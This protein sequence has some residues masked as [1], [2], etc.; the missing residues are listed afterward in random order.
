MEKYVV[1]S[2]YHFRKNK[3]QYLSFSIIVLIA[4]MIFGVGLVTIRSFGKMYG[5]KFEKYACADVYYTLYDSDWGDT[6]LDKAKAIDGIKEAETRKNIMLS[7]DASYANTGNTLNHIFFNMDEKHEMNQLE[8]IGETLDLSGVS[9]PIYISYWIK[10]NGCKIGDTYKY[11][12]GDTT[13]N[14]TIAGF[15]E[16]LMYG[17]NNCGNLAVYLPENE[18][19]AMYDKTSPN[20]H[21][22]TLALRLND[23]SAGKEIFNKLS[24]ILAGNIIKSYTYNYGYLDMS[25]R[26]RTVTANILAAILVAFSALLVIITMFVINFRIKS[27]IQ[28]EMQNMGVL[29][30]MGYTTRQVIWSMALPYI[31]LGA[32]C[33]VCGLIGSYLFLPVLQGVFG[34]LSGLIWNKPMDLM[35]MVYII[36]VILGLIILTSLFSSRKIKKL[37]PIDALRSGIKHHNFKKN[38]FPLDQTRASINITF[39]LKGLVGSIKQSIFLFVIFTIVTFTTIFMVSGLYNSV[40]EPDNFIDMV[41]EEYSTVTLSTNNAQEADTIRSELMQDNRVDQIIYYH[42]TKTIIGDE[43]VGTFVVDEYDK[44]KNDI[45]YSGRNPKHDNEIAIGC[46][47][48]DNMNVGLGDYIKVK[49]KENEI[50]Y[51]I[52]GL[53]Q[54]PDYNGVACTMSTEGYQ[55]IQ[56]GFQQTSI[57]IYLKDKDTSAAY[58]EELTTKYKEKLVS[59]CDTQSMINGVYDNFIPMMVMMVGVISVVVVAIVIVVL[60]MI[61]KTIVS[62]RKQELGILKALGYTTKQLVL[63]LTYSLL[64]AILLASILGGILGVIYVNKLWLLSFYGLGIRKVNLDVPGLWALFAST[65]IVVLSTIISVVLARRIK[66]ISPIE[67]IRE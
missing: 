20:M 1:L 51:L 17:N 38:Y 7:G 61:I 62:H 39:G 40:V 25:Q 63:Q 47:I 28:E 29:N 27:S 9:N 18:F 8:P 15:V 44:L 2:R 37:H 30:S 36:V 4:A 57:Y 58:T 33:V 50:E 55:R 16:D 65:M 22:T 45:C 31:L 60:Y 24:T 48:A 5:E 26:N 64:P 6:L 42:I 19:N 43:T 34:K 21:A 66:H 54:A 53:I 41:S 13:Y 52:V 12:S 35:A 46:V 3:G 23:S 32:I 56:K 67:L 10:S 49:A 11:V 14:F 59:Y